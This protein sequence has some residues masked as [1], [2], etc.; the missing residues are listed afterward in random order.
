MV[1]QKFDMR[2]LFLKN[3]VHSLIKS[4]KNPYQNMPLLEKP[5]NQIKTPVQIQ[6]QQFTKQIIRPHM[7]APQFRH[8]KEMSQT[9]KQQRPS[10]QTQAPL[11]S[12]DK[13]GFLIRDPT[14]TEIECVGESENLLVKKGGVIQKTQITLRNDEI[15][16]IL[17]EFSVKTNIPIIEGTF[18]AAFESLIVTAVISDILGPRFIIQKRNPFQPLTI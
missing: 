17:N 4:I 10:P 13:I 6:T 12:L 16:N 11:Q 3:F 2:E 15:K 8:A 1:N 7:T 18:K 5:E 14:I 9:P